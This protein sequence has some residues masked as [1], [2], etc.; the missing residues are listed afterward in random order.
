[1]KIQLYSFPYHCHC[2]QDSVVVIAAYYRLD[3]LG[4]EP[5]RGCYLPYVFRQAWR[6][7]QPPGHWV[8]G[9]FSGG[10]EA[11][12]WLDHPPSILTRL[13]KEKNYTSTPFLGLHNRLQGQLTHLY[14]F[15][16]HHLC[17]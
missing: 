7:I 16:H 10:K 1:M 11:G 14:L 8:L 12:V 13:K 2:G 15:S 6:P 4:F 9:L 5:K 3:G 17:C